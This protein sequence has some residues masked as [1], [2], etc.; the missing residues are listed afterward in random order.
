MC[1]LSTFDSSP[2][3][4]DNFCSLFLRGKADSSF[5][6]NS[7]QTKY[8]RYMHIFFWCAAQAS[9]KCNPQGSK[10]A[11]FMLETQSAAHTNV[12]LS[13][14]HTVTYPRNCLLFP[15]DSTIYWY[16]ETKVAHVKDFKSI[17]KCDIRSHILKTGCLFWNVWLYI[18]AR[19]KNFSGF[20]TRF[21]ASDSDATSFEEITS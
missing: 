9:T 15:E 14:R 19:Q 20:S 17:S 3:C 16:R 6:I 7:F 21:S 8:A 4:R 12:A 2:Y 18:C 13:M 11:W 10:L 1:H 5:V